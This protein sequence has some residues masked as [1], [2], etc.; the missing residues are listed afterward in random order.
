MSHSVKILDAAWETHDVRRLIVEKPGG[1]EFVPG[2]ATDVAIDAEQWR[3]EERPFTF[4]SLNTWPYLEFNIKI[5]PDHDGVTEQIGKLDVGDSLVIQEPWGAIEFRG[6]G[7]F[8]AGGAGVTPFIAIL[9][10]LQ[11]EGK[12]TGNTLIFSNKTEDDIIL[13]Q[14]FSAMDGLDCLFTVTDQ[15]GSQ[16]SR[17][18]VDKAF[19]DEQI[20]DFSQYFYVCGPQP[21]V[22]DISEALRSLGA[23]PDGIVFEK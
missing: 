6:K 3:Q 15:E 20:T 4:T 2:Q 9:R 14:E 10:D 8:I 22:D 5:Y 11:D 23:E 17:G 1:Y 21:M 19:L 7:C 13:R 18:M 12:A 16:L